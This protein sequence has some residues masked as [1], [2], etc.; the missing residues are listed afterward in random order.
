MLLCEGNDNVISASDVSGFVAGCSV[1][2][3]T[4]DFQS[5]FFRAVSAQPK[6]GGFS[7]ASVQSKDYHFHSTTHGGFKTVLV[8][9]RLNGS[10][11]CVV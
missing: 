4:P 6:A 3:R 10:I 11:Y 5:A 7:I 1:I 2:S 9:A 8:S